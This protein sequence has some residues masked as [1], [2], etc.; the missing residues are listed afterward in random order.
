ML[1]DSTLIDRR[2]FTLIEISAVISIIAILAAIAVPS[3]TNYIKM[4][5]EKVCHISCAKLDQH[6]EA[7]IELVGTSGYTSDDLFNEFVKD[8]GSL[9]PK[10]GLIRYVDGKVECSLHDTEDNTEEEGP[11][12]FL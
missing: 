1:K 4:A 7:Y 8:Y 5:E 12:P 11:D 6:F 2:G 10:N 9:C 3:V